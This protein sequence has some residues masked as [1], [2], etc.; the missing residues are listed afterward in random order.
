MGTFST[1]VVRLVFV[2]LS[3]G[4]AVALLNKFNMSFA[5]Y[6]INAILQTVQFAITSLEEIYYG[7]MAVCVFGGCR[8]QFTEFPPNR[9][10]IYS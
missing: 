1:A 4:F 2:A 10:G 5:F 9:I 3:I 8:S 7:I 6:S